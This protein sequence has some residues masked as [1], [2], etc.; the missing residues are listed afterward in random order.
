MGISIRRELRKGRMRNMPL[1][2]E[3]NSPSHISLIYSDNEGKGKLVSK[4]HFDDVRDLGKC[5]LVQIVLM[6]V[7]NK[8]YE[9]TLKLRLRK[10][11]IEHAEAVSSS[12]NKTRY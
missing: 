9:L 11:P 6:H 7:N 10:V 4:L 1:S 5:L 8:G 3:K 2:N 12:E